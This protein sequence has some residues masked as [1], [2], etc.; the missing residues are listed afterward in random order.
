MLILY[1]SGTGNSR[2]VA[3]LVQKQMGGAC[4]SIE[5]TV[6]FGALLREADKVAFVYPI[7][8]SRPPRIMQ[9]FV[10]AHRDD[11]RGKK[12]IILCTE[13]KYSG[14]GARCFTDLLPK[15]SYEVL[16]AQ[17][18]MMPN[19]VN[20]MKIF[21]HQSADTVHKLVCDAQEKVEAICADIREGRVV[22]RGFDIGARLG[23]LMQGIFVPFFNRL[24]RKSVW[25]DDD[26]IG[27][28]LCVRQCPAHNLTLRDGKAV[29]DHNCTACYRCINLCPQRAVGIYF[30]GKVKWQ[31]KGIHGK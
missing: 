26:C 21:P 9:E 4:H 5:E 23:G 11:M 8:L 2:Y 22:K 29:S 18:I 13:M 25:I 14:D 17:H 3:E 6:D 16:Y 20:N 1:F 10:K 15:G 28:G 30:H 27:C 24:I 7:Y 12:L 31:Y 19:N